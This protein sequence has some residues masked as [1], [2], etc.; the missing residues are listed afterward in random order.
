VSC[1][2]SF[3]KYLPIGC[4][5]LFRDMYI[6]TY[7]P[8]CL[9]IHRFIQAY[10]HLSHLHIPATS[11]PTYMSPCSQIHTHIPTYLPTY[12]YI[13]AYFATTSLPTTCL[14]VHRYI[15]TYL[16]ISLFTDTYLC[17]SQFTD[18]YLPPYLLTDTYLPTHLLT[19]SLSVDI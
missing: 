7:L 2:H 16:H 15:Q 19:C 6:L 1:L 9:P 14:L 13:P 17:T 4:M 5:S 8:T 3:M 11:L 10:L 18:T 12:R